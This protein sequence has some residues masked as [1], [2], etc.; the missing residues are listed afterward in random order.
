MKA[1]D[2]GWHLCLLYFC[3]FFFG[4]RREQLDTELVRTWYG[5]GTEKIQMQFDKLFLLLIKI[6]SKI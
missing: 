5:L 2:A 1:A 4:A 6:Y 3:P